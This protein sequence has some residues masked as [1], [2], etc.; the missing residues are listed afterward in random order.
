MQLRK[1]VI[2]AAS[3][4][5]ILGGMNAQ[6]LQSVV[7]GNNKFAF[8][9]YANIKDSGNLFYSSFSISTALA[10]TYAGA[11]GETEKQMSRT[12]DFNPAQSIFNNGYKNLLEKIKSDTVGGVILDIANSLWAEQSCKFLKTY[13][14]ITNSD[15]MS[16][17]KKADFVHD[18]NRVKAVKEINE[19]VEQKT[20]NKINNVVDHLDATT[21]LLLINAIYFKGKWKHQFPKN[22]TREQ[23]F[24]SGNGAKVSAMF[25]HLKNSFNYCENTFVKAI[26]IPYIGDKTSM[27]AFLPNSSNNIK[28]LEDSLTY[29]F[30][31]KTLRLLKPEEVFLS[32]PKFKMT[33]KIDLSGALSKMGMPIAFGDNA[34]FSGMSNEQLKINKVLH[35]AYVDVSEEGTEAAAATVVEV[36]ATSVEP[37]P[38]F[39]AD[40]PFIFFIID[41]QSGSVLFM[42]KVMNPN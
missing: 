4:S 11:R 42:G 7:N 25:M 3:T 6:D 28:Q 19:W 29:S 32:I 17:L 27:I 34:D 15:Y 20:E 26:S 35:E 8:Q 1:T 9:L 2:L 41:N 31:L 16:E 18:D 40:H 39:N 12:M 33:K 5:F 23:F 24:N 14:D 30:Y 37:L 21:R 10:M 36:G 22:D 38:F 13:I